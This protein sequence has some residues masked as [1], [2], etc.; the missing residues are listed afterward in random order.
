MAASSP[1]QLT[2]LRHKYDSVVR[3]MHSRG[4]KVRNVEMQGAKLL[5][6]GEAPSDAVKNEVWNEIKRVDASYRDLT[7]DIT[8]APGGATGSAAPGQGG[9]S[10]TS[11][12]LQTYTVKKGDTLSKISQQFYGNAGE[13]KRIFEANR[14]QLQD[15]DEIKPGQ[16]LRIP[17][18]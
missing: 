12:P 3:L 2:Q 11:A 1:D 13:F 18:K 16:V 17:G 6:R 15:P 14:D 9:P 5:I 10:A 4:V 7:A 8:V